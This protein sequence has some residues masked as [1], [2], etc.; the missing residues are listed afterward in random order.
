MQPVAETPKSL[1]ILDK[2]TLAAVRLFKSLIVEKYPV[3]RVMVNASRARGTHLPDSDV[4]LVVL[5]EGGCV[6]TCR[7][8]FAATQFALPLQ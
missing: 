8:R 1:A 7:C 3:Y 6:L 5:L 4:D 2:D